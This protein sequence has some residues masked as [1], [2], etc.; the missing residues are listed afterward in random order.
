MKWIILSLSVL[1]IFLTSCIKPY[2][3][4][5]PM[6]FSDLEYP[7]AVK[8]AVVNDSIAIAYVDE[9]EGPETIIFVHGLGSYLPAW[10]K[11]IRELRSRYRCIAIDLP[12]YGKSSKKLYD[13]GMAFY[14]HV[15][16]QF[17]DKLNLESAAIAGHSMG[18]Q[19]GMTL[20]IQHPQRVKRLILISP[21]GFERFSAGESKW[22]KEA[23]TTDAVKNTPVQQIR[24]NVVVNF[25]NM[26]EDAEFMVTDRIALR[27]AKDFD[28]YCYTVAEAVAG[29]V[30]E[31]VY[32]YLE[33]IRQ[34]T[35]I[36]FGENDN[37]IPNPY[38]TGGKTIAIA[39][40]GAEK[41]PH[42]K[43][44]IIPRCG[45]F[46]QFEKPEIVNREILAFME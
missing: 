7:F 31:P 4:V 21:A 45:H 22:F 29:M 24:A 33:D 38:L 36:I 26:P 2:R 39:R 28:Y 42:N 20:A 17:M 44:V 18:A 10:E 11:N 12:G 8:M 32:E 30:E 15:L 23:V 27:H 6:E 43:L 13:I 9:G 35:L 25:Y 19:I 3:Q 37:L 14:A 5:R 1:L 41:I 34:P 40:I 46:A 16:L